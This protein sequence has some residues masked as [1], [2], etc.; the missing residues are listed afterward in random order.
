MGDAVDLARKRPRIAISMRHANTIFF[1]INCQESMDVLSALREQTK[2]WGRTGRRVSKGYAS[3]RGARRPSLPRLRSDSPCAHGGIAVSSPP[4]PLGRPAWRSTPARHGSGSGAGAGAAVT[5]GQPLAAW[6][7]AARSRSGRCRRISCQRVK[8][9]RSRGAGGGDQLWP[10]VSSQPDCAWQFPLRCCRSEARADRQRR[11]GK[12]QAL[13]SGC[14]QSIPHHD[15]SVCRMGGS[16][17]GGVR[18]EIVVTR[19]A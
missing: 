4:A 9:V 5:A 10:C 12:R 1:D 6:T 13:R 19:R 16:R 2:R 11:D 15:G 14:A 8:E 3:G 18:D 17:C 7:P